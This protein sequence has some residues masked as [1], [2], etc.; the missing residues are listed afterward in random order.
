MCVLLCVA[1]VLCPSLLGVCVK[2]GQFSS[3]RHWLGGLGALVEAALSA[4]NHND[5]NIEYYYFETNLCVKSHPN[6]LL[7][8]AQ[9]SAAMWVCS[10][11]DGGLEKLIFTPTN[12]HLQGLCP[13]GLSCTG[14]N[15]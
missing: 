3:C 11:R 6:V 5:P 15:H 8:T 2:A 14:D 9:G 7:K 12:V 13:W 1:S 4:V 10:T